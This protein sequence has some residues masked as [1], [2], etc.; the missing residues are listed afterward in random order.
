MN[1]ACRGYLD[2]WV[3]QEAR[4]NPAKEESR[5][6]RAPVVLRESLVQ[7]DCKESKAYEVLQ[8][9]LGAMVFQE[10]PQKRLHLPAYRDFR[11]YQE[12][13]DLKVLPE[14]R[15]VE[16]RRAFKELK[17][18]RELKATAASLDFPDQLDRRETEEREGT[19]VTRGQRVTGAP[20]ELMVAEVNPDSSASL[21]PPAKTDRQDCRARRVKKASRERSANQE[22]WPIQENRVRQASLVLKESL[23]LTVGWVSSDLWVPE[24]FP[25][26]QD[27]LDPQG[28]QECGESKAPRDLGVP[29]ETSGRRGSKDHP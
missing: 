3:P 20:P 23:E 6:R 24:D 27:C 7:E 9:L 25:D 8:V 13:P 12:R 4:A 22:T 10:P 26:L 18:K 19:K 5:G 29:K 16:D 17:E 11:E 14:K 2:Q 21:V 1:R 15:G 28:N